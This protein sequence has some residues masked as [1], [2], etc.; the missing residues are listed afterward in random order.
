MTYA[1][2]A[3]IHSVD[4]VARATKRGRGEHQRQCVELGSAE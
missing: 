3:Y 4:G 2:T 1:M